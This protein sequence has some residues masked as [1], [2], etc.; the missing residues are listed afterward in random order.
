MLEPTAPIPPVQVAADPT[1][2]GGDATAILEFL[3]L[4]R[5]FRSRINWWNGNSP[6]V[7]QV[8]GTE[9]ASYFEIH[10]N[11]GTIESDSQ[12]RLV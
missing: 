8:L 10:S 4:G 1:I 7:K 5:C 12:N 9:V 6:A 3:T 2:M 11:G